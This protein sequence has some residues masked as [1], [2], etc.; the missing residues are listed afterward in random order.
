[1]EQEEEAAAAAATE[2]IGGGTED[3]L[4]DFAT[5]EEIA[6][7]IG[8]E[9][10][11]TIKRIGLTAEAIVDSATT[12]K[13]Q[14]PEAQDAFLPAEI[15]AMKEDAHGPPREGTVIEV[16]A[17]ILR[18]AGHRFSIPENLVLLRPDV[19]K[20]ARDLQFQWKKLNVIA[21]APSHLKCAKN[22]SLP[23]FLSTRPQRAAATRSDARSLRKRTRRVVPAKRRARDTQVA[24]M[25]TQIRTALTVIKRK[26]NPGSE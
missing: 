19:R 22:A 12:D 26:R 5:E 20:C 16:F 21:V 11:E 2:M 9:A 14:D 23:P 17:Q 8:I 18:N 7:G 1:M 15:G 10:D 25:R 6:T 24:R 3:L 13:D 4:K